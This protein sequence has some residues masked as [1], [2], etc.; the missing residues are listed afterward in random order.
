MYRLNNDHHKKAINDYLGSFLKNKAPDCILYSEDGAE[1]KTHKELF[2]QTKF[3]RE[4]LKTANCCGLV[5][6]IL[7]CSKEELGHI[8]N[9]V[10]EGKILCK[11]KIDSAKVIQN[12]IKMLGFPP[13]ELL[14]ILRN[15]RAIVLVNGVI[16]GIY[17]PMFK[18]RAWSESDVVANVDRIQA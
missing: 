2:G 14:S 6:I 18:R 15:A 9:F 4:L 11:R 16:C 13:N 10:H 1:F 8:M 7:P 3:M 17:F 5:E 12:L